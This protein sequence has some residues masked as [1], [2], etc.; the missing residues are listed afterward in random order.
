MNNTWPDGRRR[1][2]SQ[3]EHERWNASNYPGT[4]QTCSECDEPTGRCEDDTI[5]H[6]VNGTPI[7]EGCYAGLAQNEIEDF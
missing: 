2:L 1:A 3:D 4:K 7:C 6:P 5:S